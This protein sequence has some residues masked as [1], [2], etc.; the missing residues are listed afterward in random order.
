MFCPKPLRQFRYKAVIINSSYPKGVGDDRP[1]IDTRRDVSLHTRRLESDTRLS[2][3][4]GRPDEA[5]RS[6]VTPRR[7]NARSKR[8]ATNT[9][10]SVSICR[11]TDNDTKDTAPRTE[12]PDETLVFFQSQT[13]P[14]TR[15]DNSRFFA[16]RS[17]KPALSLKVGNQDPCSFDR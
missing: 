3:M 16:I 4:D 8:H 10:G 9:I 14:T 13:E 17:N 5:G 6:V 1:I 2:E 15:L 12:E 7:T 11:E